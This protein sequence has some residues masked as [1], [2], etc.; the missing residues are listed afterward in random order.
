MRFKSSDVTIC[1]P[2]YATIGNSKQK[3]SKYGIAFSKMT[4]FPEGSIKNCTQDFTSLWYH[5]Q[6]LLQSSQISHH[7]AYLGS[8]ASK[9]KITRRCKHN[10]AG[11]THT[12]GLIVDYK[13]I[14]FTCGLYFEQSSEIGLYL[15]I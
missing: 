6:Y 12:T 14:L 9:S 3:H 15:P 2:I 13:A 4:C 5:Y 1:K 11:T 10:G 7:L 8:G